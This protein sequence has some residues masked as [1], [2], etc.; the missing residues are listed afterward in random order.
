M[1]ETLFP[2][3]RAATTPPRAFSLLEGELY[4]EYAP[5]GGG[6]ARLWV[7]LPASTGAAGN[8][9]LLVGA[10]NPPPSPSVITVDPIDNPSKQSA[11][12][13]TGGVD[14]GV[15][16][17]MAALQGLNEDYLIQ[18]TD[19]SPFDA[20]PGAVTMIGVLGED[21]VSNP[22]LVGGFDVTWWLPLGDD[23]RI[24]VRMQ[25]QPQT[26]ADSNLFSVEPD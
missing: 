19:W 2:T 9:A 1:T 8:V 4:V 3:Y 14:P 5:A 23:Y 17:E 6:N 26:F 10:P 24:R 25:D 13:I 12:H 21:P 15:V 22:H 11:V 20:T 18:V 16:I 7:G